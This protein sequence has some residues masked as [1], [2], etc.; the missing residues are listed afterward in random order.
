MNDMPNTADSLYAADGSPFEFQIGKG[1]RRQ[2]LF[3]LPL[4]ASQ[5]NKGDDE[6]T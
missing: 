3:R 6:D 2:P 4:S 1:L 5:I